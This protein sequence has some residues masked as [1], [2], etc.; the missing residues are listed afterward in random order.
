MD[1]ALIQLSK[2]RLEQALQCIKSAQL[3]AEADDYKG[4][5][6]RTYYRD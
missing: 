5:A 6:N 3:L 2:Y 1:D 4:A